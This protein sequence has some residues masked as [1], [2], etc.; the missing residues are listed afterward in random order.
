MIS[1]NRIVKED[2]R[3]ISVDLREE[4]QNLSGKTILIAG[5]AGF[6]GKYFVFT[7]EYLN[8]NVLDRPC[9]VIVI[10][11]F[12][13]GL[14]DALKTNEKITIIQQDISKPFNIKENIDYIMHAASISSPI[15][16]NKFRLET[17]DVGIAGT[18]NLLEIARE[19]KVK[20]FLFFS[21]SEVYGNPD[22]KFIPTPES[23]N[24]N[25]SCTG[26]RA[27]YDE[28]KRVGETLCMTYAD[29]YN[30]PVNIVRPFNIYGPGMRFDDGRVIVNCVVAALK[31]E[32]IPVYGK[33]TNTRTF[34]YISDAI[35]G[36]FKILLSNCHKEIFNIGSDEKEIQI[37]HLADIILG[38]VK[39][40]NSKIHN[41]EA[42]NE[43][44]SDEADPNRRCPD[45]TKIRT[46]LDYKP[47][48]SLITGLKRFVAWAKEL[49]TQGF[50]V[51]KNNKF[52]KR[53]RVCGSENLK[54]I[55][56]LGKIPLAN[57]LISEKEIGKEE[58]FPLEVIY[59]NNCYLCQL[60]YVV[61]P[62][63]MFR[64]YV[65]VSSTTETFKKYFKEMAESITRQFKLNSNS[66]VVD[67]GSNDGLLLK[68][69]KELGVKVIGVEPALNLMVLAK[70]NEVHTINN[71]FNEAVVAEI[72]RIKGKPDVITAT[73]VFA[74]VADIAEF[75]NNV[76]R[77]LKENGIFCIEVQYLLDTIQKLT[78][79][80]IYHEHLS[81]FSI[82][83]LNEFFKR[84]GM[85][86]FKIEHVDSHGGS[87][88]VFIQKKGG[89]YAVDYSVKK[90]IK[91]EKA[92]ALDSLE[93]Y[94]RF[95]ERIYTIKSKFQSFMNKI[96]SEGKRVV[97]YGAPAKATT[98]LNFCDIDNKYINYVV[99]DNPLKQG[100]II[101]GVK[102]PIVGKEKLE[103]ELP[104]YIIILAWN[105]VDEILK[106]NEHYRQKGV[107]FI[108]P[109]PEPRI[110]QN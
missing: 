58:L 19:K 100:L 86:L 108:I 6:I 37:R 46:M 59:C 76:K 99:E 20:G 42:P 98:F 26:P 56:S 47:K 30:I 53:C 34:C 61:S 38:L 13:S 97:G 101:P 64:H 55:I 54:K 103:N 29:I 84:H 88:R 69:F 17:I 92:A 4:V 85:E 16:Y 72:I 66:L 31:G 60:S 107:K 81:Y 105:F 52:E 90:F 8:K 62:E 78:F 23:Y 94:E 104:D 41:V 32:K 48:I 28:P 75:T 57:N 79:D 1:K 89:K 10:D 70:K 5:G 82:L 80:N 25:V 11:N 39:N 71:F 27:C 24:G 12:I 110:I 14:K 33:G 3:R 2:I 102:I 15:F 18:R 65:Y 49:E 83:S 9:K 91:Q 106:K 63:K 87:I 22:P 109:L 67:I 44:Y 95:A 35:V 77:L 7:L 96:K 68:N 43:T 93:T 51:E 36:F 45:L 74:H 73:N 40:N 21:S 50:I